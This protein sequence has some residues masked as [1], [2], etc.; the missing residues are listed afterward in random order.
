MCSSS[1][2]SQADATTLAPGFVPNLHLLYDLPI[3]ADHGAKY[4]LELCSCV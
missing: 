1:Q 3:L 4:W 2:H